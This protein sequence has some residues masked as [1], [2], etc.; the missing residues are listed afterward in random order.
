ME[1]RD[2]WHDCWWIIKK[3]VVSEKDFLSYASLAMMVLLVSVFIAS[4]AEGGVLERGFFGLI[5]GR[6]HKKCRY[7]F[8]I[9]TKER[10]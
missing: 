3:A 8:M 10:E 6:L 2:L 7:T 1:C 5:G 9:K 4:V